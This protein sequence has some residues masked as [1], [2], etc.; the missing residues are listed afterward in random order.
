MYCCSQLYLYKS[1][2]YT[3]NIS[4]EKILFTFNHSNLMYDIFSK[5]SLQYCLDKF[6]GKYII[7]DFI[8]LQ[9]VKNNYRPHEH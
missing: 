3:Q 8:F 9:M 4:N 7:Y 2:N 5:I 1:L 6:I